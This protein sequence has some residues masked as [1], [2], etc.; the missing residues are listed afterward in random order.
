MANEGVRQTETMKER[1]V[2]DKGVRQ[3]ES[4]F[5]GANVSPRL[6]AKLESLARA[7]ERTK[8]SVLRLLIDGATPDDVNPVPRRPEDGNST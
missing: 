8:S 7:T 3:T 4:V 5:I 6:A 1:E 2:P